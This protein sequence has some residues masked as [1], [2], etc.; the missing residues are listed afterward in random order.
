M[1]KHL[2][3]FVGRNKKVNK[4]NRV[5]HLLACLVRMLVGVVKVSSSCSRYNVLLN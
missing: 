2:Y 1:E 4:K 5:L 3:L